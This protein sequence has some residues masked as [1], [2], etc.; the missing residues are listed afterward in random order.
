MGKSNRRDT[1][2]TNRRS[3]KKT[4]RRGEPNKPEE[5]LRK[6][7]KAYQPYPVEQPVKQEPDI[8]V[9]PDEPPALTVVKKKPKKTK[10]PKDV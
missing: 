6:F 5:L 10:E 7:E 1:Q 9:V 2:K 3:L 4:N 8:P